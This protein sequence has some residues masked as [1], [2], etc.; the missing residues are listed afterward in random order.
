[1]KMVC[2]GEDG[3]VLLAR[4]LFFLVK[5]GKYISEDGEV[6]LAEI[7]SYFFFEDGEVFVV[8]RIFGEYG[9][10]VRDCDSFSL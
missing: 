4:M 6:F 7:V 8:I 9:R 1:M 2:F 5:I 3:E 10:Y